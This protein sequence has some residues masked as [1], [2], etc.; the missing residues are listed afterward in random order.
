[1]PSS[2][3][4]DPYLANDHN[5]PHVLSHLFGLDA[6][7]HRS[8]EERERRAREQH[9]S[10]RYQPGNNPVVDLPSTMVYGR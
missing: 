2:Y 9:A 5:R 3:S 6:I 1:M 4:N 10:I 7:G 8:R